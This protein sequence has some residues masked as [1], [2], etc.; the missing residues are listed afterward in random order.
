M[1]FSQLFIFSWDSIS[2]ITNTGLVILGV[3]S[4]IYVRKEY[5]LK[6]RP[7][8]IVNLAAEIKDENWFF[9]LI[10]VNKGT[11]TS[12]AKIKKA[13][14]KIGD[15]TYPTEFNTETVLAPNEEKKIAP[16]GHINDTGRKKILGHEYRNNRVEILAEV[17]S[18]SIG[19]RD[20]KYQSD[21][22]YQVDISGKTPIFSIIKESFT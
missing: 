15:E 4:I 7:F 20:Y 19:D 2:A 16:I 17:V 6:R 5:F 3:V 14:L 1:D 22:E 8:I 12:I 10:L 11:Y 13:L 9:Y 21:F 18:K